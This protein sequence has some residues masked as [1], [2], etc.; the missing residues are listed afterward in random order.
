[1]TEWTTKAA[2]DLALAEFVAQ[3]T[4]INDDLVAE[5]L[6]LAKAKAWTQPAIDAAVQR[7][8][9]RL[10]VLEAD[11]DARLARAERATAGPLN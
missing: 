7:A 1:M 9:A 5:L 6:A 8:V 11:F 10:D 2:A 4:A 3:A